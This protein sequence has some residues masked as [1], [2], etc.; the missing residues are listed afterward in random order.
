MRVTARRFAN[1]LVV[2]G[3]PDDWNNPDYTDAGAVTVN[4]PS[5]GAPFQLVHSDGRIDPQ[6]ITSITIRP[7]EGAI[8]WAT[9]TP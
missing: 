3:T 6:A 7:A 1:A 8:L 2:V 5:D 9:P 4:L